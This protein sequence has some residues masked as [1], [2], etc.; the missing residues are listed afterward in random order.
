MGINAHKM[1][2]LGG[3]IRR[4]GKGM[5]CKCNTGSGVFCDVSKISN[6][7]LTSQVS[8]LEYHASKRHGATTARAPSAT[9]RS[10]APTETTRA[11][12][13]EFAMNADYRSDDDAQRDSHERRGLNNAASRRT[14][15]P[16][17]RHRTAPARRSRRGLGVAMTTLAY[18]AAFC[19]S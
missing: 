13:G 9:V 19:V 5:K 4:L 7:E 8:R 16:S 14:S 18:Y 3:S 2:D 17:F 15:P 11:S 10:V 1:S 6:T 12:S